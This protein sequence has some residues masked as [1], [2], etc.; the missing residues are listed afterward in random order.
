[1]S[2]DVSEIYNVVGTAMQPVPARN[3]DGSLYINAPTGLDFSQWKVLGNG[4]FQPCGATCLTIPAGM[5]KAGLDPYSQILLE[6]IDTRTDD[7]MRLPDSASDQ[8]IEAVRRF[9]QEQETVERK[10]YLFKRGILLWGPPGSGKTSTLQILAA[11]LIRAGGIVLHTVHP[12]LTERG[13]QALRRVEKNRPL[14]VL[15]EDVDELCAIHG[16]SRLLALLDGET[17]T[18]NVVF[19]ATTNYPERLDKRFINRPGRFDEIIKVGMPNADARRIYLQSKLQA[20]EL[21]NRNISITS[22]VAETEGFS[23]AHV[24]ELI[25]AVF[26]DCRDY[27]ETLKRLKGM[28]RVPNSTQ[29]EAIGFAR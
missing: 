6:R 16:E 22:L 19:I 5:F 23:I 15:L 26:C 10:G 18:D 7:L 27:Q 1:M 9:W 24:R 25:Y 14:I 12:E 2:E 21:Q 29:A 17:Q 11:D 28:A 4:Q 8:I 20:E 3:T 13:L